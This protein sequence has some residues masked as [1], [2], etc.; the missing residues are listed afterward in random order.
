MYD[1]ILLYH[2]NTGRR[3][4]VIAGNIDFWSEAAEDNCTH[5]FCS[6]MNV[7]PAKETPEEIQAKLKSI[8]QQVEED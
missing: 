7:F 8:K 4:Y 5:V 2:A 3:V 1:T 6:G